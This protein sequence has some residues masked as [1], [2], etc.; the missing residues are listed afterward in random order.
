MPRKIYKIK[1]NLYIRTNKDDTIVDKANCDNCAFKNTKSVSDCP[2][3][4]TN[5]ILTLPCAT[6][7]HYYVFKQIK[8]KKLKSK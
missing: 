1:G 2:H 5:G 8:I 3:D 4:Y 7:N 6:A